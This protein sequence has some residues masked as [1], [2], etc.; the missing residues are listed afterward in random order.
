MILRAQEQRA[1]PIDDDVID[2]GVVGA[3]ESSPIF[4]S[5]SA[6]MF[7]SFPNY[8]ALPSGV[9]FGA[10]QQQ[11]QQQ[12]QARKQQQRTKE[13]GWARRHSSSARARAHTR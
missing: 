5:S 8:C 13:G 7:C 10:E 2:D 6:Y 11:Q 9:C 1:V 12:Q 4:S 3:H